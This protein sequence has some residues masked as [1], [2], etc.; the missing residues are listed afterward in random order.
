MNAT[1]LFFISLAIT[2]MAC[3]KQDTQPTSA[4]VMAEQAKPNKRA[5]LKKR[6]LD[7]RVYQIYVSRTMNH[8][9]AL[10][11]APLSLAELK[12]IIPAKEVRDTLNQRIKSFYASIGQP[13]ELQKVATPETRIK[14]LITMNKDLKICKESDQS[15]CLVNWLVPQIAPSM[16]TLW[17][18]KN[19][20]AISRMTY[21]ELLDRLGQE[22]R[23]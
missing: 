14:N 20:S 1:L 11:A 23:K 10:K 5:V 7:N 21:S 3:V 16:G 2:G 22:I 15:Y 6:R 13:G 18:E 12:G 8:Q 4:R 17:L 19:R 9:E